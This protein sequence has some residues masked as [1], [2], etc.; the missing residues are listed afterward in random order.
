MSERTMENRANPTQHIEVRCMTF[1]VGSDSTDDIVSAT[2]TS[3]L[4]DGWHIEYER[5]DINTNSASISNPHRYF[6]RLVRSVEA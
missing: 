4:N 6:V 3:W 5:F 1:F 2:L